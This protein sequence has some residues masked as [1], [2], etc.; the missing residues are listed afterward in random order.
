MFSE[1]RSRSNSF[2]ADL[3]NFARLA[4]FELLRV[5]LFP[6]MV[7]TIVDGMYVIHIVFDFNHDNVT[8]T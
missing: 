1:N 3:A 5:A 4:A 6:E 7:A 2:A 8:K